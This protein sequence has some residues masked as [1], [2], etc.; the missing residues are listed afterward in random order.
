MTDEIDVEMKNVQLETAKVE[1]AAK[2]A[3]LRN[4]PGDLRNAL[5]N[6]VAIAAI[7]AALV[8]LSSTIISSVVTE[9]QKKLDAQ[10]AEHQTA[11]E[12]EKAYAADKLERLKFESQLILAVVRTGNPDQAATNL[13]FLVDTGLVQ[14][15]APNL[16]QYL[17]NRPAGQGKVL[18]NEGPPSLQ[19]PPRTP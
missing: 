11:L 19:V 3:D 10:R 5:A 9:H 1:L 7:I 13:E 2:Q 17:R 4:R 16:R 6:P 8:T 18:P 14:D 12:R 15:T